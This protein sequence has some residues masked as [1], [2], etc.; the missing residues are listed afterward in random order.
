[1]ISPY[2]LQTAEF[3]EGDDV[4]QTEPTTNFL[5]DRGL[6]DSMRI[7]C[8]ERKQVS[9]LNKDYRLIAQRGE[10]SRVKSSGGECQVINGSIGIAWQPQEQL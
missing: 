7:L 5:S 3:A 6:I 9:L 1:M 8:G 2:G 10:S 4:V